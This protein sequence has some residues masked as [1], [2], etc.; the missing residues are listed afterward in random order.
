MK[1][2]KCNPMRIK[3]TNATFSKNCDIRVCASIYLKI[4]SGQMH[5]RNPDLSQTRFFLD[6]YLNFSLTENCN[7]RMEREAIFEEIDRRSV[8][9][10]PI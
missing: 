1:L 5:L 3:N 6:T 7:D 10:S 4:F 8:D 2:S 9:P